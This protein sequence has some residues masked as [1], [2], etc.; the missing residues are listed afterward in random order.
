MISTKTKIQHS[1]LNW[2][3]NTK[4]KYQVRRTKNIHLVILRRKVCTFIIPFF[5]LLARR[6][7]SGEKKI[8]DGDKYCCPYP[9]LKTCPQFYFSYFLAHLIDFYQMCYCYRKLGNLSIF[10]V[11]L[12]GRGRPWEAVGGRG[13]LIGSDRSR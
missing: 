12:G 13:A 4:Q 7:N 1:E 3:K 2:R 9:S 11:F 6:Q 10:N 5:I 8:K